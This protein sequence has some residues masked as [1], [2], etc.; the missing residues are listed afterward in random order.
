M[1]TNSNRF[2]QFSRQIR[3]FADMFGGAV[4]CAAA[5]EA[6]RRPSER[7]LAKVGLSKNSFDGLAR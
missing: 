1:S 4:E 2:S 6:G 7:A 3:S 5:V